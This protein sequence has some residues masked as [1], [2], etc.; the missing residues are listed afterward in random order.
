MSVVQGERGRDLGE[1]AEPLF[2]VNAGSSFSSE[3]V[4]A[5]VVAIWPGDL[6]LPY[7]EPLRF[8]LDLSRIESEDRLQGLG[9]VT[10]PCPFGL[11]DPFMNG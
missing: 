5:G 7:G 9:W 3:S 11:A 8:F 10:N 2:E 1:V 4:L 6:V